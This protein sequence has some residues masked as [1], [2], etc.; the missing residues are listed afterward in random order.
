MVSCYKSTC[1]NRVSVLFCLAMKHTT[2]FTSA[3]V[4]EFEWNYQTNAGTAGRQQKCCNICSQDHVCLLVAFRYMQSA[5][6]FSG[7]SVHMLTVD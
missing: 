4:C 6:F 5:S 1:Y 2:E 7:L 3:L